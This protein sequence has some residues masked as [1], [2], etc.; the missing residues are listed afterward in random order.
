MRWLLSQQR[1]DGTYRSAQDRARPALPSSYRHGVLIGS[2]AV[3]ELLAQPRVA[4]KA[5]PPR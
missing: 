3:L 4:S 5:A 2:W 1:T